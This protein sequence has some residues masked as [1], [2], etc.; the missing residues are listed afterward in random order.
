MSDVAQGSVL[1]PVLFNIFTSDLGEAIECTLGNCT[2]N[3]KLGRRVD[4][5]EH[6]MD[7]QKELDRLYQW[8]E[9]NS[10]R[11]NRAKCW[12]RTTPCRATGL[13]I[14][15][16]PKQCLEDKLVKG[17]KTNNKPFYQTVRNRMSARESAELIDD[18]AVAE[19]LTGDKTMVE[20]LNGFFT[21]I[22]TSEEFRKAPSVMVYFAKDV[23]QKIS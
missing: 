10:M 22:L 18:G 17:M 21:L 3:I 13:G 11:L 23:L 19:E 4:L 20:K 6:R 16:G 7:L 9:V 14:K 15:L 8:T 12:V 5:L 1:R 2:D